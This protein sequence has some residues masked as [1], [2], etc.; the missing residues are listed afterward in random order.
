MKNKFNKIA[1]GLI[2]FGRLGFSNVNIC[3]LSLLLF[4]IIYLQTKD[5]INDGPIKNN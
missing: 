2:I 1:M 5:R 4:I 3:Y